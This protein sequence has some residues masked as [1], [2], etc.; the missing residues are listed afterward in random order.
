MASYDVASNIWQA[1]P[2]LARRSSSSSASPPSSISSDTSGVSP[3]ADADA[4]RSAAGDGHDMGDPAAGEAG[5]GEAG[6]GEAGTADAAA[7]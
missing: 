1:L 2:W 3:A 5:A 4:T 6:A 7:T